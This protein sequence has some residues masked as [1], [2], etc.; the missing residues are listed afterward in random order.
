LAASPQTHFAEGRAAKSR[1]VSASLLAQ[2]TAAADQG[3]VWQAIADKSERLQTHSPTAAMSDLFLAQ[4]EN[5][6][7]YVR[8]IRP[9]DRQVGAIFA[10]NGHTRGLDLFDSA[11][12]FATLLPKVLRGYALDAIDAA[13]GRGNADQAERPQERRRAEQFLKAVVGAERAMFPAVGLGESWRFMAPNVSG[14]PLTL[15]GRVVHL[16]AFTM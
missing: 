1:Q 14:G 10:I 4:D 3:Q 12:T 6:E 16:S 2:G 7:D 9:L 11:R 13:P 8:A 5:V 15:A